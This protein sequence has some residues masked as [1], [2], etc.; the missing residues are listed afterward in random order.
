M[1]SPKWWLGLFGLYML[2]AYFCLT[3]EGAF[4]GS[5]QVTK[6]NAIMGAGWGN[7]VAVW[8]LVWGTLTWNFNFFETGIGIWIKIPLMCLSAAVI[9]PFGFEVFRL[10]RRM[11]PF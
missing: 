7:P 5:G 6:L 3:T 11:L 9:I 4:I 2:V 8:N 1:I 10:M